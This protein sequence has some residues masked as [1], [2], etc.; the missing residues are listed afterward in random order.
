MGLVE[1]ATIILSAIGLSFAMTLWFNCVSESDEHIF[2]VADC[3]SEVQHSRN[4]SPQEAFLICEK[5]V[6]N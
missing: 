2:A 5:E 6:R 4:I 3:M 1:K